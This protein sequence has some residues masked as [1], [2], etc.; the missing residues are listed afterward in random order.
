MKCF[1]D[2]VT[3]KNKPEYVADIPDGDGKCFNKSTWCEQ[4]M[5]ESFR[6]GNPYLK[7]ICSRC[8]IERERCL[9]VID[10]FKKSNDDRYGREI[11]AQVTDVIRAKIE[12]GKDNAIL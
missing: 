3:C 10:D 4:H 12:G 7:P 2:L 1:G 11:I 9:T 8:G 5:G 6:G